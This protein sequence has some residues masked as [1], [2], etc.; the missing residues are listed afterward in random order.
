MLLIGYKMMLLCNIIF[1]FSKIGLGFLDLLIHDIFGQ[2][3]VIF[4]LAHGPHLTDML[5]DL[6]N[7]EIIKNK[8]NNLD[9]HFNY[10]ADVKRFK[11]LLSL[12][13]IFSFN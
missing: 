4:Y 12:A 8:Y 2:L 13:Q 6:I 10:M 3:C 11:T 1:S 9:F 7:M 5:K